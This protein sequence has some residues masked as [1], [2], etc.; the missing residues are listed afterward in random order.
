MRVNLAA[1]LILA[2]ST[3]AAARADDVFSLS[4][5]TWVAQTYGA[6]AGA[7]NEALLSANVGVGYH[8]IDNLSL[9]MEAAGYGV[10]Q[11]GEDTGAAEVRLLMRHH[12]IARPTW[13][14]FAD[15]AEGVFEA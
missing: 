7:N 11:E 14:I 4:G 5:G 12:L 10:I 9:N 8:I 1:L 15:V 2:G 6:Y 3:C 13:S